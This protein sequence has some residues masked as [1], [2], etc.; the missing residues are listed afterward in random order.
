MECGVVDAE[1]VYSN[2]KMVRMSETGILAFG[3]SEA[4]KRRSPIGVK[5]QTSS[6]RS[7]FVCERTAVTH[8]EV[9]QTN[10]SENTTLTFD[11]YDLAVDD[12]NC[13]R[14]V[15][16]HPNFCEGITRVV[17]RGRGGRR[18]SCRKRTPWKN[19]TLSEAR[20][21]LIA[22]GEDN[23]R[24]QKRVVKSKRA[25]RVFAH[26]QKDVGRLSVSFGEGTIE[27]PNREAFLRLFLS[28]RFGHRHTSLLTGK[29]RIHNCL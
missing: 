25:P 9:S 27:R 20:S 26:K 16:H 22:K 11:D 13:E 18:E 15:F 23:S 17:Q 24:T 21:W 8:R 28:S 6:K 14:A 7:R 2:G 10:G 19:R 4:M 29:T 3:K 12:G 5:V 1:G